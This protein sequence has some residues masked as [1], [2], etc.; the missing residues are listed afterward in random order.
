MVNILFFDFVCFSPRFFGIGKKMKNIEKSS[1]DVVIGRAR[2][3]EERGTEIEICL[4][5]RLGSID[6]L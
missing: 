2:F 5:V 1:G 4:R 6:S 3:L